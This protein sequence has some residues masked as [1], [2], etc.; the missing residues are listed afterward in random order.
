[1]NATILK[2][3]RKGSDK[4]LLEIVKE[5]GVSRS[6]IYEI[7]SGKRGRFIEQL[8][9]LARC[10]GGEI[11]LSLVFRNGV[12]RRYDLLSTNEEDVG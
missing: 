1:M 2:K 8:Q 12:E 6:T 3:I 9:A 5:A 4:A 11:E 7:E 10:Y